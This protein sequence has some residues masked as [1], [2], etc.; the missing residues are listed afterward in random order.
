M[1]PET[2]PRSWGMPEGERSSPFA[3]FAA[4]DLLDHLGQDLER[5]ADD[6]EVGELEDRCVARRG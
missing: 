5:V 1:P 4:L 3:L 6:A 2:T